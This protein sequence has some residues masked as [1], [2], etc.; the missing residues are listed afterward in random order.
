MYCPNCGSRTDDGARFCSKCGTALPPAQGPRHATSVGAPPPAA[1]AIE[2]SRGGTILALGILSVVLL[3]FILGIP[4]WV[5]GV[6]DL[7]KMKTGTMNPDQKGMTRAGMVLGIIGTF[8][9]AVV[10]VA[11]ILL[12]T[13]TVVATR[14]ASSSTQPEGL[15]AISPA[16]A[17]NP[18]HLAFYDD[19]EQIRGQTAE[20]PPAIFLVSLSIGYDP[21]DGQV[22]IEIGN[23][24]REIQDLVLRIISE[25]K[26]ADL[27]PKHYD[28]VQAEILDQINKVMRSGKV[29]AV[30]FRQFVVQK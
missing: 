4:A 8:S 23:R 26:A 1:V 11:I 12:V 6:S 15:A 24:R 25:K 2:A 10:A 16:Y 27:A 13:A 19:I 20:N 17:S 9:V 18:Q 22:S 29:R 14:A 7:R 28:R 5:M 30:S 3:G 21:K